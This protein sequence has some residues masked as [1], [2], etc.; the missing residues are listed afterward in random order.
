[1]DEEK[2]RS[3]YVD[4]V[5]PW[6]LEHVLNMAVG[7]N[8]VKELQ[9]DR[10]LILARVFTKL[11]LSGKHISLKSKTPE[12]TR[13]ALHKKMKLLLPGVVKSSTGLKYPDR[14]FLDP[15]VRHISCTDDLDCEFYN[16]DVLI[17]FY[18]I[19]DFDFKS[20]KASCLENPKMV[21]KPW[22]CF[23]SKLMS[24]TE[25]ATELYLLLNS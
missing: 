4:Y 13:D 10:D 3:S 16:K 7:G 5:L 18:E 15:G 1:M 2:E 19:G 9:T 23:F 24:D 22:P 17:V 12:A 8:V 20:V 25:F 21:A 6:H 14:H 11:I